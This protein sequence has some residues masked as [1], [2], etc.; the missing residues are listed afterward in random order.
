MHKNRVWRA[1]VINISL[2]I[3]FFLIGIFIGFVYR[4]NQI[5]QEQLVTTARAHFKNIVLTRRWNANYGGVFV[6]KT[7]GVVSNPYL[8]NPDVTAV[9]GTVY[10]MK[11]PALMTREISSYAEDAGDFQYHITSLKPLNPGNAPDDFEIEALLSFEGGIE[12]TFRTVAKDGRSV[13]RYMAPLYVEPSCM[14]CHAEQGYRVGEVRGGISVKF[15]VTKV[16]K[17]MARNRTVVFALI[18]LTSLAMLSVIF[19]LVSRLARR[20]SMAYETIEKMSVTDELTK[21]HNR[22]H[23]H[24]RLDEELLRA[25]R[26]GSP[27]SL[28]LL[29]IDHFKSVNDRFG[30]QSG[31]AVL[32]QFAERVKASTRKTDV[33]ARYGGEEFAVILPQCG[34]ADAHGVAEKLR[35]SVEARPFDIAGGRTLSVTV[36]IGVAS[37]DMLAE[38]GEDAA[39]RV[40]KLADEALYAAK[41]GGRNRTVV[42]GPPSGFSL[43]GE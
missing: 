3:V 18:A 15:D 26:L 20:L 38:Q 30:H 29:D 11:N 24:A 16:E 27:L 21:V 40:V 34:S 1:F 10:T 9:D 5:I 33:T 42:A 6:K 2:I 22:R 7:R 41:N 35:L 19:F 17:E 23:F 25:R 14:P 12:E 13:F 36:S 31:D 37:L 32:T 28:M 39:E 4:T 8:D 43:E